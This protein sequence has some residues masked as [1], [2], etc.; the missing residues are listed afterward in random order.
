MSSA[1]ANR[2]TRRLTALLNPAGGAFDWRTEI[3]ACPTHSSPPAHKAESRC[4]RDAGQGQHRDK[5]VAYALSFAQQLYRLEQISDAR[6]LLDA[7]SRRAP[8]A[9]QA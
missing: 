5:V 7:F 2:V 9:A 4:A 6:L 1:E 8:P 3:R